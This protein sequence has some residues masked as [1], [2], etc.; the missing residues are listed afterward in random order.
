[1]SLWIEK[2]R[3]KYFKEVNFNHDICRRLVRLIQ[4]RNINNMLFQGSIGCGKKTFVKIFLREIFGK[5][6]DSV[7]NSIY[8][9]KSGGNIIE[10][11][12]KTTNHTIEINLA[13]S[14]NHDRIIV[15]ELI[16]SV[17]NTKNL[18]NNIYPFKFIILNNAD[19]IS[20]DAQNALRRT[21]E[22]YSETCK[23]IL[24]SNNMGNIINPLISRCIVI[25]IPSPLKS[26][27]KLILNNILKIEK[28]YIP[29]DLLDRIIDNNGR[30]LY[31][32]IFNLEVLFYDRSKINS[33]QIV[34]NQ[35][36][37]Y[38]FCNEISNDI[39]NNNNLKNVT[40]IRKKLY[41]LLT[42]CVPAKELLKKLGLFI[43]EKVDE[44]L[45]HQIINTISYYDYNISHSTKVILHLE[46]FV[47]KIMYIIEKNKIKQN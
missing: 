31:N 19:S 9:V 29:E 24:L 17:A 14:K 8:T 44:N 46:A 26:Q 20:I 23:L 7:K 42:C 27:I 16:K 1:M 37:W 5:N 18:N 40:N 10:C 22:L 34:I 39:I 38:N 45:K 41:I 43:L 28:K 47:T 2:Y 36:D 30:N 6:I 4:S 15:Q 35:I 33:N 3:P 13:D 11:P 32:N 12:I 21:M 25:R